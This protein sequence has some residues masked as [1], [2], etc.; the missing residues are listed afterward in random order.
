M[1][2]PQHANASVDCALFVVAYAIAKLR[3]S[4]MRFE[5]A[6]MAVMRRQLSE[7][8]LSL[9]KTHLS[10]VLSLIS[11]DFMIEYCCAVLR[12]P[13]PLQRSTA[14]DFRIIASG[15]SIT[16]KAGM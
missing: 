12:G 15:S 7:Q 1:A 13:Q 10:L 2:G 9:G 6:V 3:G 14:G 4:L 11:S 5:Q 8:L 16:A